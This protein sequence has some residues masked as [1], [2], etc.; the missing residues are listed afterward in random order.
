M[1]VGIP[2]S[3]PGSGESRLG[4][5]LVRPLEF[6]WD[7]VVLLIRGNFDVRERVTE[8]VARF[9]NARPSAFI[10]SSK[11]RPFIV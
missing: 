11:G 5:L 10:I 3:G 8:N 9:A 2:E 4:P 1:L 7:D 6:F